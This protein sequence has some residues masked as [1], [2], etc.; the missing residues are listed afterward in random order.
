MS[1]IFFF[2]IRSACIRTFPTEIDFGIINLIKISRRV[3]S[4]NEKVFDCVK[5]LTQ[6]LNSVV[7]ISFNTHSCIEEQKSY[8]SHFV[9]QIISTHI[10]CWTETKFEHNVLRIISFGELIATRRGIRDDAVCAKPKRARIRAFKPWLME[11]PSPK[12][13]LCIAWIRNSCCVIITLTRGC[14]SDYTTP[15][16]RCGRRK[17]QVSLRVNEPHK[18]DIHIKTPLFCS[19]LGNMSVNQIKSNIYHN[20]YI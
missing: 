16:S 15:S 17:Y 9:N 4:T 5:I 2:Y 3:Q 7:I 10:A 11:S 6:F 12:S 19:V 1:K 14:N 8:I 20:L 13:E 18:T